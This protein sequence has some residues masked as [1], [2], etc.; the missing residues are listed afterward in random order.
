[1]NKQ[2]CKHVKTPYPVKALVSVLGH[3]PVFLYLMIIVESPKYTHMDSVNPV[4][5]IHWWMRCCEQKKTVKVVSLLSTRSAVTMVKS[6]SKWQRQEPHHPALMK[7]C[8]STTWDTETCYFDIFRWR[9]R[10][11]TKPSVRPRVHETKQTLTRLEHMTSVRE[12]VVVI[13]DVVEAG[14]DCSRPLERDT[15]H[16][17]RPLVAGCSTGHEPR[18]LHGNR[19]DCICLFFCEIVILFPSL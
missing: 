3:K 14:F 16:H 6:K 7:I 10:K 11:W 19:R 17:S 5:R 9:K 2:S 8:E 4:N 12:E 1:M 13:T 15:K 18:L